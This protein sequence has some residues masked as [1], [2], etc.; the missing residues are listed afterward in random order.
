MRVGGRR[1]VAVF[2]DRDGTLIEDLHYPR[3][4]DRVRLLPGAADALLSLQQAAFHLV[5]VGN[6]SGL[7]QGII[8]DEQFRAVHYRFVSLLESEGVSLSAVRYCPHSPCDGCD[9]RKPAPGLLLAVTR[10][11]HIDLERSFMVGDKSSD[12]EAGLRAGC[13]TVLLGNQG[14]VSGRAHHLARDWSDAA[15]YILRESS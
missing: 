13:R 11:L 4:A 5:V 12:V 10:D 15:D 2:L 8:S 3:E 9:C 1:R 6:Q 7:G 14:V